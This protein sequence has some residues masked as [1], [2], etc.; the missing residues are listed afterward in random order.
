[1]AFVLVFLLA[2]PV[3]VLEARGMK[4]GLAAALTIVCAAPLR[5]APAHLHHAA[6]RAPARRTDREGADLPAAGAERDRERPGEH[7]RHRY[8]G[9]GQALHHRRIHA[10]RVRHRGDR[11][12]GRDVAAERRQSGADAPDRRIHRAGHLVLGAPRPPDHPRGDPHPVGQV[13]RGRGAALR[14]DRQVDGRIPPRADRRL[15]V[16]RRDRD[17]RPVHRRDPVC[18]PARRAR[19]RA[20]LHPVRRPVRDR[21]DRRADRAVHVAAQGVSSA[22]R[23]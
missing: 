3:R 23:W 7:P 13:A 12:V 16:D 6:A 17:G 5:R 20:E 8:A 2:W 21:A 10:A 9:V 4:R 15:A 22:S 19:V 18:V 1:M 14:R 11:H